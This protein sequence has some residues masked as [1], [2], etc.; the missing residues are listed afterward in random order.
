[1]NII[2]SP[3]SNA[4]VG[5]AAGAILG[6]GLGWG[7]LILMILGGGL[8]FGMVTGHRETIMG[9][10]ADVKRNGLSREIGGVKRKLIGK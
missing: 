10:I 3:S 1:M 6:L 9:K 2:T 8:V 5:V 4:K 7:S